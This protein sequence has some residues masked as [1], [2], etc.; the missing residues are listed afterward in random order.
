[1]AGV[2]HTCGQVHE[3]FYGLKGQDE[4]HPSHLS[5]P[6]S[7]THPSL[8]SRPL[9]KQTNLVTKEIN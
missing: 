7:F 8:P 5:I 2:I 9:T 1:M 3:K 4:T 6:M